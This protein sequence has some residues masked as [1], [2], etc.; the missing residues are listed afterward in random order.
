MSNPK[1]A[2]LASIT[3]RDQFIIAFAQI[4]KA[5]VGW[6]PAS[7]FLCIAAGTGFRVSHWVETMASGKCNARQ[8]DQVPV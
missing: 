5:A 7:L 1:T 4:G 3:G 8:P 2:S 6:L